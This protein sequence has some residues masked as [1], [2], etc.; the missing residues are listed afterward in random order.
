MNDIEIESALR[1]YA[2]AYIRGYSEALDNNYPDVTRKIR[3]LGFASS[4]FPSSRT[5]AGQRCRASR[6]IHT[7]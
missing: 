2:V 6:A 4:F 7:V 5:R 1:T 3:E